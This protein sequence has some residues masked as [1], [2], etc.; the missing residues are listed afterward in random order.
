[1]SKWCS[2]VP[3]KK[4]TQP[5]AVVNLKVRSFHSDCFPRP[6]PNH[7]HPTTYPAVG[8]LHSSFRILTD[9]YRSPKTRFHFLT[10]IEASN[11]ES[12][13]NMTL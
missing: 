11:R 4:H 9:V 3:P 2:H 10:R 5:P 13:S 8:T 7:F 1:M 12:A 6:P